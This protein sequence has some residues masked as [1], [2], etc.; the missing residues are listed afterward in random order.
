MIK[1][2]E[3]I[4]QSW[5]PL[6]SDE[7][8]KEYFIEL[9]NF[10]NQEITEGIELFPPPNDIFTALRLTPYDKIKVVIVGQDPYH[11]NG[12]AHG[13]C[14]SVNPGIKIPASLRNIFKELHDDLGLKP[15]TDGF[16]GKWAQQGVLMIN[17]TLTVRAH[18]AGS[19]K[20]HGWEQFT[21]QLIRKV[22]AKSRPVVFVLWGGHAKA[23]AKLITA[24]QHIII[25]SAHPSPL[26]AYRGFFGSRPS[27]K[28]NRALTE[29]GHQPI[30]WQ[31]KK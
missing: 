12:Q 29:H 7:I 19:H 5:Q 4:P 9:N 2:S 26:S 16:L 18:Q 3:L 17:S 6:L 14:F 27:S 10:L 24:P 31:L 13:L 20:G 8:K 28:I 1:L 25:S 15:A 11:D 30:D 23:K 21:D 22:N